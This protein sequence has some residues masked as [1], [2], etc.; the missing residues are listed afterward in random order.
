MTAPDTA[1]T[2]P[3]A[4]PARDARVRARCH[5]AMTAATRRGPVAQALDRLLPVAVVV[6]AA[7][8]LAEGLRVAG[9]L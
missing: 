2:A 1:L 9:V 7:I 5:A 3:A 6:Y 8:V 4:T